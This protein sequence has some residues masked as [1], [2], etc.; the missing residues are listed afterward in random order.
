MDVS[1]SAM[2]TN[3]QQFHRRQSVKIIKGSGRK[4]VEL[5]IAA[6]DNGPEAEFTVHEW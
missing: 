6:G 1:L 2:G 4:V 3:G 5:S